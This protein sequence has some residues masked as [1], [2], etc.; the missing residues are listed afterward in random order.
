MSV[1][2]RTCAT[3]AIIQV[4]FYSIMYG[5]CIDKIHNL[6]FDAFTIPLVL[7]L[8]TTLMDILYR[9]LI[10]KA[11]RKTTIPVVGTRPIFCGSMKKTE[12]L[13]YCC[14]RQKY[15]HVK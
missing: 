15:R 9:N 7:M 14:T 6:V 12:Y 11:K 1:N 13:I 8:V 10:G 2:I 4:G 5:V 3:A